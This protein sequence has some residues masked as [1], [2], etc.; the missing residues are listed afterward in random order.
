M[1]PAS[2][3]KDSKVLPCPLATSLFHLAQS[4]DGHSNGT[5]LWLGAQCLSA[6]LTHFAVPKPGMHAIELGSG[7]GLTAL[8]IA[9]LGC[10]VTATD[11]PWV[12]SRCLEKNIE[13]NI[14][15]LPPGSGNI[16]VR[17]LDWTVSP[18][19][20]L[21]DHETIIASPTL[22]PPASTSSRLPQLDQGLDLIV[23]ADT[24]YSSELVTPFLQTLHALCIFSLSASSYPRSPTIF[25]CL[26]RR[27]PALTDRTLEEAKSKWR[28][29][30][31]RIPQHKVS[32][33]LSKIG[34]KWTKDDWDAVELWKLTYRG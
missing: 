25:I 24:I 30:V 34:F 27:D 31:Q 14:S 9:R 20:W 33:A 4:D 8:A 3:T 13:N 6:Y 18:N 29:V 21:W 23:T 12:I 26:E 7:I 11:L 16:L 10:N 2:S 1:L 32:K 22:T 5:A 15:Q 17:E 19:S 28:F